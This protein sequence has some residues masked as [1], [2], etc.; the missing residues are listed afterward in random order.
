MATKR[1]VN[2]LPDAF[3]DHNINN[4]NLIDYAE[5]C[6]VEM[7]KYS[8]GHRA[9][10]DFRDGLKPVERRIIWA[11]H[12]IL[13]MKTELNKAA[14]Y[15]GDV[16]G[17]YH[18]HGDIAVYGTMVQMTKHTTVPYLIGSGNWGNIADP[19]SF[20]AMRY[21][22]STLSDYSRDVLLSPEYL[23]VTNLIPNFDGKTVEPFLLP[24]LLPNLLVNGAYGIGTGI[25]TFIPTFEIEGL[26]KLVKKALK[27]KRITVK[28]CINTLVFNTPY[29]G[30][31]YQ[32]PEHE[33][34]YEELKRFYTEGI[35]RFYNYVDYDIDADSR[36]IVIFGFVPQVGH[37]KA[38]LN[39]NADE[40][41]DY[42]ID[43]SD[44]DADGSG[45]VQYRV[46]LKSNVSK[47]AFEDVASE[48]VEYF[49]TNHTYRMNVVERKLVVDEDNNQTVDYVVRTMPVPQL[50]EEWT[51][52]RVEM[53][54]QR[55]QYLI[56]TVSDKIENLDLRLLACMNLDVIMGALKVDNSEQVL[57]KKLKITAEQADY[58]LSF[59][60]SQLKAMERKKLEADLKANK[61]ELARLKKLSKV[62]QESV[63]TELGLLEKSLNG[64]IESQ[65]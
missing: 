61:T 1:K 3:T 35:G 51:A 23:K 60:L 18:P 33:D 21:T 58:I 42:C 2:K 44:I 54:S 17:K 11:A 7:G 46:K 16:I 24:S 65:K 19:K 8:I 27:G 49:E 36:E 48:V 47:S 62:P 6:T 32:D 52:W 53:E 31:V 56:Q 29:G 4:I 43:D 57:I 37:E 34:T 45:Y 12:K 40:R 9:F 39:C 50:I 63:L 14:R 10:P 13:G 38:V 59:K 28:D 5:M 25:T 55:L 20:A 15:V 26:T 64:L 22:E 41:V 30:R